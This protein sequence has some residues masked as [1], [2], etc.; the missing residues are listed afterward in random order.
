MKFELRGQTAAALVIRTG[1]VEL[2]AL[3]GKTVK[4]RVRIALEGRDEGYLVSAIRRALESSGLKSR[5]LAVSI[6]SEDALFRFFTVPQVPKSE[7]DSVVQFE[8]R[9][10]VPFKI[11]TLVWDYRAI[12]VPVIRQIDVIFSAVS[13]ELFRQYAEA[14]AAAGVQPVLI[15][16]RSAGLA[17]LAGRGAGAESLDF[18]C[19]VEIDQERAHLAIVR[20]QVPYLTRDMV[21]ASTAA[22]AEAAAESGPA[23]SAAEADDAVDPRARRLMSELSVSINFFVREYPSTRIGRVVLFGEEGLV[24]P[25]CKWLGEQLHCPVELGTAMVQAHIDGDLPLTFAPA[26]GLIQAL[27]RPAERSIDFMR[28]AAVKP[29]Q[30][31]SKA[32]AGHVS[33][34][35]IFDA[36]KRPQAVVSVTLAACALAGLFFFERLLVSDEQDKLRQRVSLRPDVAAE[37]N[38]MSTEEVTAFKEKVERQM[39]LLKTAIEQRVRVAAKLDAV[40]RELPD[41]IWLTNVSFENRMDEAGKSRFQMMVRGACY[42]GEAGQELGAIQRFG[43]RVK[44]NQSF[45][46]GFSLAQVEQINA[47]VSPTMHEYR[48]FQLNCNSERL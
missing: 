12:P 30:V 36:F 47:Q 24:G 35:Q 42:L 41:G 13:R 40:A 19:I 15:E 14:L 26:V 5:K 38:A 34:A 31:R 10:Y 23:A 25:W 32:A 44:R 39:N 45:I 8:A 28:R 2:L 17:R 16:P 11:D 48:S 9:K 18:S 6:P 43:E 7:L 1:E 37:V 21:F 33:P 46:S 3:S 22:P 27:N 29:A 4:G 20:N